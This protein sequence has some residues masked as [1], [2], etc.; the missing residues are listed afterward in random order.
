MLAAPWTNVID[1]LL[2][3]PLRHSGLFETPAADWLVV[4]DGD[5]PGH[6]F[7]H[8]R[9]VAAGVHLEKF[10][11]IFERP[12]P[13]LSVSRR[14]PPHPLPMPSA[15]P[16]T[17]NSSHNVVAKNGDNEVGRP[18]PSGP[19][20]GSKN[21]DLNMG[22]L[23]GPQAGNEDEQGPTSDPSGSENSLNLNRSSP[24]PS[25]SSSRETSPTCPDRPCLPFSD[26][27]LPVPVASKLRNYSMSGVDV[28]SARNASSPP[29]NSDNRIVIVGT[30]TF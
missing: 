9:L 12:P 2:T 30:G 24:T 28:S 26:C 6:D 13:P 5:L 20:P 7:L 21:G 1:R 4:D 18:H 15:R 22:G 17:K 3:T 10:C 11:E 8:H 27:L 19:T 23:S 14:A 29:I 16:G 25:P